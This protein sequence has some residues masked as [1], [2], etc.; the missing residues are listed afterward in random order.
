MA[1]S[2]GRAWRLT[3]QNGGFRPG[4]NHRSAGAAGSTGMTGDLAPGFFASDDE[5][6]EMASA[7]AAARPGKGVF[8]CIS[9]MTSGSRPEGFENPQMLIRADDGTHRGMDWMRRIADMGLT[10]TPTGEFSRGRHVIK[11][12]SPPNVLKDAYDRSFY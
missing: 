9:Q 5:L 10:V 12:S 4:Q 7:I 1:I 3:A 8:Q 6:V 2:Y 11:C